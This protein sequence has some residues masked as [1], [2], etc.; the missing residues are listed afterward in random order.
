[1]EILWTV[2]SVLVV[3]VWYLVWVL[4]EQAAQIE[5]LQ[6]ALSHFQTLVAQDIST[7]SQSVV[8]LTEGG[9]DDP[10]KS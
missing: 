5:T 9:E 1:M 4:S 3:V 2:F 7:L 6:R 8:D 10:Q